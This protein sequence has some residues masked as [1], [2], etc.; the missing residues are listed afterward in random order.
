MAEQSGAR[1][2]ALLHTQFMETSQAL[3]AKRRRARLA[4][5]QKRIATLK[6][7]EARRRKQFLLILAVFL[8]HSSVSVSLSYQRRCWSLPK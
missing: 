7:K 5:I 1:V 2:A 6:K 3:I 8:A 4:R